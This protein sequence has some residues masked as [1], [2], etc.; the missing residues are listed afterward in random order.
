MKKKI[1]TGGYSSENGAC[2][3]LVTCPRMYSPKK[4]SQQPPNPSDQTPLDKK[5]NNGQEK[6][7]GSN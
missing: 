5:G 2:G 4:K 6:E 1:K 3:V 7:K